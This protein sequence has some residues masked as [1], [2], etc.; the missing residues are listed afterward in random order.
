MLELAESVVELGESTPLECDW[1]LDLYNQQDKAPAAG[2]GGG[3]GGRRG[4]AS[5]G[6]DDVS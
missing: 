4:N 3:G 6:G 1:K 2:G 5:R